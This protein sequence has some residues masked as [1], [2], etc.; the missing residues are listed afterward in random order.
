MDINDYSGHGNEKT[1]RATDDPYEI[2]QNDGNKF[3]IRCAVKAD[4]V[5]IEILTNYP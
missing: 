2:L 3:V 5:N 1:V 4:K